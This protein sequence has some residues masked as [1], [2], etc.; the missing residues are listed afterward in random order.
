[1]A[2]LAGAAVEARVDFSVQDD[3]RAD[4]G[5]QGDQ[6][7]AL[8][9]LVLVVVELPQGRAVRVVAQVDRHVPMAVEHLRH[10]HGADGDV[11]RL[12][13][14]A[15]SVIHRA[16][17][18]HAHRGHLLPGDMVLFYQVH[19]H[20]GQHVPH[21]LHGLKLKGHLLGRSDLVAL[22]H[23][24]RFQIG[25]ADVNANIVHFISSTWFPYILFADICS[26]RPHGKERIGRPP[27][28]LTGISR[29][30]TG[31][32]SPQ[33]CAGKSALAVRLGPHGLALQLVSQLLGGVE[34]VFLAAVVHGRHLHNGGQIPARL[35]TMGTSMP[36][37][38]TR[39]S[40]RPKRS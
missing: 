28:T 32:K 6:N 40:S 12:D 25:A 7:Q 37:M 23:Q 21:L 27:R 24:P 34:A 16:G 11:H 1:M 3:A 35:V 14:D 33:S 9:V 17:E 19:G 36:R 38:F 10:R 8:N 26:G 13:D 31:R 18:P 30:V 20:P 29:F 15:L 5:A 4:A 22:V 39:S 2:A